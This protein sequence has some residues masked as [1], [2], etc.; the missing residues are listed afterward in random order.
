[1]GKLAVKIIIFENGRIFMDLNIAV[2]FITYIG[3]E[4]EQKYDLIWPS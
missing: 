1:V 3:Q 4:R 2:K